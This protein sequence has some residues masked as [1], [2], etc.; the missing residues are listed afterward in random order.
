MLIISTI[1]YLL[2]SILLALRV[3]GSISFSRVVVFFLLVAASLNILVSEILSLTHTLDQ[4]WLF[5]LTQ[6]ILCLV[7]GF[8]LWDPRGWIFKQGMPKCKL[9][10]IRP[11]GLDWMLLALITAVFILSLYIGSLVPINNSDS[12]HTHLPRIYYWI[13]HGSLDSWDAVTVTQINKPINLSLQGVWIFLLGGSEKLFFLATW[14]ALLAAIVLV[15]TMARQLGA[16]YRGAH[17]AS[18][19]SLSF[20]V[21]LLQ[22]FSYQA[23]VFVS[24]F[25]LASVA[26]LLEYLR[27]KRTIFIFLSMLPLVV[28]LGAK[29]TALFILPFYLLVVLIH[30][31]RTRVNFKRYLVFA[32]V[33]LLLFGVFS[34]YKYVQNYLER[35]QL[36]SS[37]WATHRFINPPAEPT[38]PPS[39]NAPVNPPVSAGTKVRLMTNT[40][41]Y[42]HQGLSVDGLTGRLKLRALA[43]RAESFRSLSE[44]LGLDLEERQFISEGDEEIFNYDGMSILNEDAAWYGPLSLILIPITCLVVLFGRN[45]TRRW[46]LLGS[47]AFLTAV[48]LMVSL[49]IIGWSPTNGRYLIMPML[50]FS[51]LLFVLLPARRAAGAVVT[52]ILSL[53]AGYL[54]FSSLLIND[55]RPLI[56]QFTLYTYQNERLD[57]SDSAGFM[58]RAWTYINDRVIE[59]LVLTSPDRRDIRNQ[60]YYANLF[61]QSPEDIPDIEFV[62]AHIPANEPLYMYINKTVIEYALFGVNKTRDLIPVNSLQ[63]VP[64]RALLLVDKRR[65]PPF[66]DGFSLLAEN[67]HYSIY[68]MP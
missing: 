33:F 41:R 24:A 16:N 6:A 17:L 45:K 31:L 43:L 28:G 67:E 47:F 15:F 40:L 2:L 20:P 9:E 22:T 54:A 8:L 58:S 5:L 66:I 23:D 37:M 64:Q 44:R 25:G 11:R 62:N 21:I 3:Y 59:D 30:F 42:L 38:V 63:S 60:G 10:G 65:T 55:S 32:G 51:P 61:H 12:L 4:P 35:D 14:Y 46:Y 7:A 27:E 52:I 56:T 49:L 68:R 18:L 19:M 50:V 13:Q 26:F 29:N 57:R 53:S 36:E 39:T 1:L 48:F 34:S